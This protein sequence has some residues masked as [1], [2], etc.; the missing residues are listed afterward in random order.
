MKTIEFFFANSELT[1]EKA[2]KVIIDSKEPW[3]MHLYYI[4][5]LDFGDGRQYGSCM[6]SIRW[7]D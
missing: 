6:S 4:V 3:Q 1:N 7:M 5:D 2:I